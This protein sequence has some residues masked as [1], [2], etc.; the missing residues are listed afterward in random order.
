MKKI[1]I[2]RDGDTF[3]IDGEE[4]DMEAACKLRDRLMLLTL[5]P[6]KNSLTYLSEDAQKAWKSDLREE[7]RDAGGAG[8]MSDLLKE[9]E[10][11]SIG[12]S[13]VVKLHVK[14][15]TFRKNEIEAKRVLLKSIAELTKKLNE[16]LD[17]KEN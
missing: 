1:N 2:K 15:I 13:M 10:Y 6:E 9:C 14:I 16:Y 7:Y 3:W 5:N 12:D 8:D 17:L 11:M 4:I